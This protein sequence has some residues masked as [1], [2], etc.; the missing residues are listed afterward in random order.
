M[1]CVDVILDV[2]LAQ[3]DDVASQCL[4]TAEYIAS[5]LISLRV[6]GHRPIDVDT[7]VLSMHLEKDFIDRLSGAKFSL[8]LAKGGGRGVEVKLPD[9]AGNSTASEQVIGIQVGIISM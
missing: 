3:T 4:K 9:I 1:S 6:P 5:T 2:I 7:D 8:G